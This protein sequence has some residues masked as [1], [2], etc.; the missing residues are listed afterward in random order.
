MVKYWKT[1]PGQYLVL[2]YLKLTDIVNNRTDIPSVTGTNKFSLKLV[3]AH[4]GLAGNERVDE[5]AK[6][7]ALTVTVTSLPFPQESKDRTGPQ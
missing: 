6:K 7:R 3:V 2:E 4:E 1:G 5:E